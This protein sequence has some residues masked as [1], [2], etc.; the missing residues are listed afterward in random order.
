MTGKR[1]TK[2]LSSSSLMTL[3]LGVSIIATVPAS[4]EAP[5]DITEI[6]VSATKNPVEA[7]STPSSVSV[8]SKDE[9]DD[10]MASNISDV[11]ASVPGLI[12]DGG[13]RRNGQ[14]PA[15]RGMAGEGVVVLF[16]GVRQSFL[17]GHDGRFFIEPDLL[18]SA[19]V[20][21]GGGSSLYGSG[22]VGGVISL[23]TVDAADLLQEGSNAGYR[24]SGG[25]QDVNEEWLYGATVFGRSGDGKFDTVASLS[26]RNSDD[27]AL[28]DGNSL[29]A[30]DSIASGIVKAS[31][32]VTD[33]LKLSGS[34]LGYRNDAVEPNNGLGNNTGDLMEK[35]I[36][37]D[38]FRT[39]LD[40]NPESNLVNFAF[41]GYVNKANVK[42]SDL[43]SDRVINRDVET[44]GVSFDN[45]SRF[46]F[47]QNS[48]FTLTYGGEYYRDEQAGTDTATP[49]GTR[50]GVPDA[51]AKTLGL[52]IQGELVADTALGEIILI[53]GV[54][55]DKFKN[56]AVG[57]DVETSEGKTSP[58]F[59][60]SWSPVDEFMIF[61]SYSE[62][63]RAPSYNEIFADDLH[64]VIPLGP[65]VEAPNFFIPNADLRPERSKTW[66]FGAGVD[67]TDL[68]STGDRFTFKGAY[69]NSDVTDLIDLEVNF[70]FSLPCFVP[71][72]PGTC[73]AGTS[74]NINTGRAE[75]KGFELEGMYDSEWFR[76][77]A[78]Y[79]SVDGKDKDTGDYV[80]ILSPNRI[81]MSGEVKMPS[82]DSRLGARMNIASR[83]DKVND[84]ADERPGYETLD[85]FLVWQPDEAFKGLR[86]DLGVDNV[87][88]TEAQ[89]VFAGVVDPG[90]NMKARI[91]WT[92]SF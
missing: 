57:V 79:S 38:T 63:F 8:V 90:R 78:S 84:P 25:Y 54:R 6:T 51:T 34:W 64:F 39:G 58:K 47:S 53:P 5:A 71:G 15:I 66:E 40:F 68:F 87:F 59:A 60:A 13:P 35:D 41:V 83:F 14:T 44:V 33:A 18:K 11:F 43:D 10:L 28:G 36:V 81:Y 72:M 91:S 50:G 19:E 12:F 24:L 61:G 29:Q 31:Y 4:A 7:F 16:D 26:F 52:F 73:N 27:I 67:F 45:R 2:Q 89:T 22:A 56:S 9:I 70:E 20:V 85:L 49:D 92:G 23:N 69:F 75:L 46:E 77:M 82:L 32:Q 30:D 88:D 80:G 17:S 74:R 76:L 48:N 86:V 37:S 65:G 42:E 1:N 55:Y 21:R 3:M 62:A